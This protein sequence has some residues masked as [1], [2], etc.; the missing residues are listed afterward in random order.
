MGG[1]R[2]RIGPALIRRHQMA[3]D[4]ALARLPD[5]ERQQHLD[6]V[7]LVHLLGDGLEHTRRE[8]QEVEGRRLQ[9]EA[10]AVST[11]GPDAETAL[12]DELERATTEENRLRNLMRDE[13]DALRALESALAVADSAERQLTLATAIQRAKQVTE[14]T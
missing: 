4:R 5:E 3:I 14:G 8:L 12:T 10:G 7:A 2:H 1:R 11:L 13:W 6:V 9:L